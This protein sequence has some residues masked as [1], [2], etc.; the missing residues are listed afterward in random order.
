MEA[1]AAELVQTLFATE[2]AQQSQRRKCALCLRARPVWTKARRAGC[3][4]VRFVSEL[5]LELAAN[6]AKE[7]FLIRSAF[8]V[9]ELHRLFHIV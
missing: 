6:P 7:N 4:T 9:I 3:C 8:R 5:D 2:V 1:L